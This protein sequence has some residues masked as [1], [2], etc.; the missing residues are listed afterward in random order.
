MA[1]LADK[2]GYANEAAEYRKKAAELKAAIAEVYVVR[3]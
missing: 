3:R 2:L 1:Q